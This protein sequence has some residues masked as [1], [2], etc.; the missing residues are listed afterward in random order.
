MTKCKYWDICATTRLRSKSKKLYIK[1]V[2]LTRSNK[3]CSSYDSWEAHFEHMTDEEK[4]FDF[5]WRKEAFD[6]EKK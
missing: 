4:A 5:N 2:C 1:N 6:E 3:N